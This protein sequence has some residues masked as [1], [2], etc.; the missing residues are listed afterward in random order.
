VTPDNPYALTFDPGYV[1]DL[2]KSSKLLGCDIQ[3]NFTTNNQ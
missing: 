1:S 2:T 3:N